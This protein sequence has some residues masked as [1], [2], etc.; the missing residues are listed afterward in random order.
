ME[1]IKEFKIPCAMD[2]CEEKTDAGLFKIDEKKSYVIP[3]CKEHF[4][5]LVTLRQDTD[6]PDKKILMIIDYDKL[7]V[8]NILNNVVGDIN[9]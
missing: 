4:R 8:I 6:S 9:K 1:K 5:E 7:P 2:G 3:L